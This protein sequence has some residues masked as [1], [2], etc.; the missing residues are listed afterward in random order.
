MSQIDW[1]NYFISISSEVSKK[2]KD[3]ST[4]VGAVI[5]GRNNG[6][7]ST[8][9]NG[10]PIGVYDKTDNN[11]GGFIEDR[12]ERPAKYKYTV[13]ADANAICLAAKR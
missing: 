10:F 4:K 13:H 12:Y 7:V 2:S 3:P 9:F 1:D 11:G 6:I 8:G 5:V